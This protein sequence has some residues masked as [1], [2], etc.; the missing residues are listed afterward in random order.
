MT[1]EIKLG[2]FSWFGFVIPLPERLKMIKEAGFDATSVWWEDEKEPFAICKQDMPRMVKEAGLLLEN[3]H[4][5]YNNSN[6]LW[7]ENTDARE[8]IVRKHIEWL[9]DCSRFN[10]PL[11]VMHIMEG[12]EPPAPNKYGIE[13]MSHLVKAAE[14]LGVK[15]AIENTLRDD[16]VLF[17]L[18]EIKSSHMGFCYDSSHASLR[19][20]RNDLLLKDYGGRLFAT[21]LSDNDGI[22]DRHWLPGNGE[23]CWDEMAASFPK[24]YKGFFTL[25][26][27]PTEEEKK[28]GPE[29]FLAKAFKK[30]VWV[31]GLFR[32]SRPTD[33]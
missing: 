19:K 3:I 12:E 17:L 22:F 25:E 21:H 15:I 23:I 5:P 9:N 29:K 14:E 31:E 27:V 10:I 2:I 18:S 4:V 16:S 33:N 8:S 32:A 1:Y 13:S 24:D 28:L 6:D 7:S 11:M 30:I 26:T 20:H